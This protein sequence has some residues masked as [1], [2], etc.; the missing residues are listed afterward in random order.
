MVT[1]LSARSDDFNASVEILNSDSFTT[2]V[3][4]LM[5]SSSEKSTS[6]LFQWIKDNQLVSSNIPEQEITKFLDL[7]NRHSKLRAAM[8]IDCIE[9]DLFIWEVKK[10]LS[11]KNPLD[12]D[13]KQ[14]TTGKCSRQMMD[15]DH[16][17]ILYP[18]WINRIADQM[19]KKITT[20]MVHE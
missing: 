18:P 19:G 15:T 8:K 7:F 6:L 14:F 1:T 3:N 17:N 13:W 20:G 5:E 2:L 12:T 10:K 16:F 11:G 9:S 4:R